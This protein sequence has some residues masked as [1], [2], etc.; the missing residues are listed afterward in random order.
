MCR[1]EPPAPLPHA[2]GTYPPAVADPIEAQQLAYALAVS[3]KETHADDPE[4]ARAIEASLQ[5]GGGRATAANPS[6]VQG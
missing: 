6:S 5:V 3:K 2:D 4:V 1:A